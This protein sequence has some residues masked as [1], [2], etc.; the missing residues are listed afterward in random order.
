M[1]INTPR[2]KTSKEND[3]YI[4]KAAIRHKVPYVTTMAA[5]LAAVKGIEA[6]K[7]KSPELKSLQEYH[8]DIH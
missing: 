5:A 1:V 3:A 7:E 8:S 6:F 2:G 4:R